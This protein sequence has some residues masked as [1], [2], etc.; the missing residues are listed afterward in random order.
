MKKPF[1]SAETNGSFSA[2]KSF[3]GKPKVNLVKAIWDYG[4]ESQLSN[5][6]VIVWLFDVSQSATALRSKVISGIRSIP[7]VSNDKN[8]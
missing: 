3:D 7:K 6:T 8:V 2:A 4:L 5:P 1:S